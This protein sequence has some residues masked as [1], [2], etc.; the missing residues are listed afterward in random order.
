MVDTGELEKGIHFMR[1]GLRSPTE[2]IAKN[3]KFIHSI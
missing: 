2:D 3:A 1:K